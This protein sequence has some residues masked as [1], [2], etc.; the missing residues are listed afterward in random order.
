M[1]H[2]TDFGRKAS[3]VAEI[4]AEILVGEQ[5]EKIGGRIGV[6]PIAYERIK[7]EKVAPD[8]GYATGS[9]GIA[10]ALLQMYQFKKKEIHFIRYIDDP[11]PT[12]LI[13]K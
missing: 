4:A 10:A 5:E 13:I 12:N 7:P 1:F 9:A 11:Y 2:G 8:F 3:D 6:W